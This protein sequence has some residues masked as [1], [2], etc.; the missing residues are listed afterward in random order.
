MKFYERSN[1]TLTKLW[2][3]FKFCSALKFWR[4][5]R[6]LWF[7]LK[8]FP[9]IYHVVSVNRDNFTQLWGQTRNIRAEKHL[10][11]EVLIGSS[12]RIEIIA[13][14]YR[15]LTGNEA[16]HK[17]ILSSIHQQQLNHACTRY[18]CLN[19]FSNGIINLLFYH[20]IMR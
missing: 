6:Y 1:Q 10:P 4:T 17:E 5:K 9:K 15:W 14:W 7:S 8:I 19:E 20:K 12:M 16:K 2:L 11:D 18:R 3:F 13:N